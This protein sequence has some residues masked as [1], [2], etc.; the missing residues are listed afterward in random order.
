MVNMERGGSRLTSIGVTG[1]KRGRKVI[2]AFCAWAGGRDDYRT[3]Y[4]YVQCIRRLDG[5]CNITLL[6]VLSIVT[7]TRGR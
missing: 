6:T 4:V 5:T 3:V 2:L 1:K 7:A